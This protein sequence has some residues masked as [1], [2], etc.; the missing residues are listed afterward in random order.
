MK[1]KLNTIQIIM[2]ETFL[3]FIYICE[4]FLLKTHITNLCGYILIFCTA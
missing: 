2:T 1:Y 3:D 4:A